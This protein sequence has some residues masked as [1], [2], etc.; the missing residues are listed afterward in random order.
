[1]FNDIMNENNL[2]NNDE[3]N[4][5]QPEPLLIKGNAPIKNANNFFKRSKWC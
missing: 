2:D 4:L 1:M 5:P 3:Q